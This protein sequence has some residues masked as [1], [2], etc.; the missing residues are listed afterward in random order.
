MKAKAGKLYD[1][2]YDHIYV[3]KGGTLNRL[4]INFTGTQNAADGRKPQTDANGLTRHGLACPRYYFMAILAQKGE[5][6]QSIGFLVEH[7][8]DY[9]YDNDHQ[10]PVSV[11]PS[12]ALSIDELE[13]ET[14]LDF[15]CNVPDE[16][17]NATEATIAAQ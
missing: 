5:D 7:R 15:F 6:Y 11:T 9:G 16:V 2:N 13:E 12:H 1:A 17:E 10:A 4:L 3:A 14:G 8:D